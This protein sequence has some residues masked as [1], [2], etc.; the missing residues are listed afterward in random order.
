MNR[1]SSFFLALS[2]V[3]MP[4]PTLAAP[5]LQEAI[6]AAFK[7]VMTSVPLKTEGSMNVIYSIRPHSTQQGER[8]EGSADVTFLDRVQSHAKDNMLEDGWFSVNTFKMTQGTGATA[9]TIALDAP[10]RVL[11]RVV[12]KKLFVKVDSLP[13]S[14]SAYLTA[15]GVDASALTQH[16]IE[17]DLSLIEEEFRVL[18]S[19]PT[20]LLAMGSTGLGTAADLKALEKM[21]FLLVSRIERN[22]T[23]NGHNITRVRLRLNPAVIN[24]LHRIELNKIPR[25]DKARSRKVTLVNEQFAKIRAFTSKLQLVANLDRTSGTLNRLEAGGTYQEPM[26]T[27]SLNR[28]NVSICKTTGAWSIRYLGGMNFAPDT[29]EVITAPTDAISWERL[30][31]LLGGM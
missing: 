9:E 16:W 12:G 30:G 27:C 7:S 23:D 28:S 17:F 24:A 6:N 26:K 29:G 21:P 2:V 13:P 14:I 20:A 19:S 10:L 3:A 22:W 31:E 5:T 15:G 25:T 18:G 11:T 1:F 8:V 4:L